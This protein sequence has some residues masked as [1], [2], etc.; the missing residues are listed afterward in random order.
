MTD[1]IWF[2]TSVA[3]ASALTIVVTAAMIY[4]VYEIVGERIAFWQR[5]QGK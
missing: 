3:L 5:R 1:T 4:S 2:L